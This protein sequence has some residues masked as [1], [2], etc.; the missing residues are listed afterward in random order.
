MDIKRIEYYVETD[1]GTVK[2]VNQDSIL[3]QVSINENVLGIFAV[4]D[5]MGG[6]QG[7]EIA[8]GLVREDLRLWWEEITDIY[9]EQKISNQVMGK[10]L[11][12]VLEGANKKIMDFAAE[13]NCRSGTTATILLMIDDRIIIKHVGDSRIYRLN[14]NLEKLT[15]D[16]SWVEEQVRKGHMSQ[17]DAENHPHRHMLTSCLGINQD[18]QIFSCFDEIKYG[19]KF[20]VCS[21]GF[22]KRFNE[23]EIK[24]LFSKNEKY[25]VRLLDAVE[26]I[27]K[28]GERDN[29]SGIIVIPKSLRRKAADTKRVF[30]R[31]FGRR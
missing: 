9:K 14:K 19:D 13:N 28:R 20:F 3:C 12:R 24:G 18:F 16:H 29:I 26:D 2:N 25:G 31:I 7:G 21:D 23:N 6:Y 15:Q 5:G 1:K 4:M 30:K 10:A 8:S 22:Y 11:D 17:K 27:K